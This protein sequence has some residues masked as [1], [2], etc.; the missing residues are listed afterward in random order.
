VNLLAV[1]V[2]QSPHAAIMPRVGALLALSAGMLVTACGSDLPVVVEPQPPRGIVVLDGFIQPGLTLLAD[3]GTA[4]TRVAFGPPTEF[5]AGGFTL[6]RDTVLATSSRG[7]GNLLYLASVT[8]GTVRRVQ[9]PANSNPASARLAVGSGGQ[10]TVAVALRDSGAV[11]VLALGPAGSAPTRVRT[12][13][14]GTCPTDMVRFD[15]AW[16]IVDSNSS[17]RTN[18]AVQGDVRLI[19]VPDTGTARD[20]VVLTGVRGSGA[21]AHLVNEVLYVGAGGEADFSRFPYTLRTP[22]AVAKVDLRNRRVLVTRPLPAGSYGGSLQRGLDGALY[23]SLYQDL[24]SFTNRVVKLRGDDLTVVAGGTTP[25]LTLRSAAGAEVS[26][27]SAVAD[28][29][30]RVHCLQNGT[31]SATSL[32]VFTPGGA[33]VRRVAA[34]QGGVALALR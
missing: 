17:C 5:D 19:R 29:L 32:L 13:V 30:G 25:W 22:G 1:E 8:T 15:G 4:S 6:E 16:W 10:P 27:G 2:R 28:A 26:C 9:L 18:Y 34:G 14:A 23:V 33:E 21:D 3:T 24:A 20:T 31:A 12:L 7:A 11:V